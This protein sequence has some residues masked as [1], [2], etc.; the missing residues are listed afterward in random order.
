MNAL[1]GVFF[2]VQPRDADFSAAALA[3]AISI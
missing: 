2:H 3:C 1:A